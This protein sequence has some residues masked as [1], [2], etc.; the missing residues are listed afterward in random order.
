LAAFRGIQAVCFVPHISSF[1]FES[2]SNSKILGV[3]KLSN[4]KSEILKI[5][6]SI[7]SFNGTFVHIMQIYETYKVQPDE[8]Q[9]YNP[10]IQSDFIPSIQWMISNK[11]IS[12][13]PKVLLIKPLLSLIKRI[14]Q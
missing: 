1:L 8:N 13:N 9:L 5:S 12:L 6:E 4:F 7:Q 11:D 14:Y 2:F 10:K 3:T